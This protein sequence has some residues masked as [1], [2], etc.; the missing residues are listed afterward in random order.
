MLDCVAAGAFLA[1]AATVVGLLLAVDP[2]VP[3]EE[4]EAA[5]VATAAAAVVVAGGLVLAAT[6]LVDALGPAV[7]ALDA[8][9]PV[10]AAAIPAIPPTDKATMD[11][12]FLCLASDFFCMS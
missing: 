4:E 10:V 5:A 12:I 2:A 9:A 3:V 11:C 6:A 7:E 8:L 1:W